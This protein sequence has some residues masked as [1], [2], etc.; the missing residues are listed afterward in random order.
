MFAIY[1]TRGLLYRDTLENLRKTRQRR[2]S[3][4]RNQ[5]GDDGASRRSAGNPGLGK[6][7]EKAVQAYRDMRNLKAREP[8]FH[9][10]QIM[11][12]PVVT[13]PSGAGI[14]EA[15]KILQQQDVRQAPVLNPLNQMIGLLS[16]EDLLR[17]VTVDGDTLRVPAGKVVNDVM[18]QEVWSAD[19]VTDIRRIARVMQEWRLHAVPIVNDADQLIGLVSRTDLLRVMAN[20]P[21]LSLWT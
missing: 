18:M 16:L 3:D 14:A 8:I 9:A 5:S 7:S 4:K 2:A 11:S 6:L 17:L 20:N 15:W 12:T 13:V 10:H 21:P 19:P 1:G